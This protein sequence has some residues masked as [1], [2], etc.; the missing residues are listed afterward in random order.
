MDG[1]SLMTIGGFVVK[2]MKFSLKKKKFRWLKPLVGARAWGILGVIIIN[3]GEIMKE[4][5]VKPTIEPV[6]N[7]IKQKLN[8]DGFGRERIVAPLPANNASDKTFNDRIR[9]YFSVI[10]ESFIESGL[11]P[12]VDYD[13]KDILS[14]ARPL[15]LA[16]IRKE[17]LNF[18]WTTR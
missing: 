17:N 12:N 7:F 2:T 14:I 3:L 9:Y 15:I 5:A 11:E 6:S 13:F 1:Y 10:E 8:E 18:Y 4:K 16:A